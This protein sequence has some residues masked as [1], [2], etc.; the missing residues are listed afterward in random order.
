MCNVYIMWNM[1]NDH[2][3]KNMRIDHILHVMIN[4]HTM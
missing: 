3:M 4:K 2:S 1:L